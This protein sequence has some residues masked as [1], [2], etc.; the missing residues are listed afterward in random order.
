MRS[1]KTCVVSPLVTNSCFLFPAI[2]LTTRTVA[3][4]DE[5]SHHMIHGNE[6]FPRSDRVS[7]C[8]SWRKIFHY[9]FDQAP[10]LGINFV[11]ASQEATTTTYPVAQAAPEGAYDRGETATIHLGQ[12]LANLGLGGVVW[13]CV[14]NAMC[15][16]YV[17]PVIQRLLSLQTIRRGLVGLKSKRAKFW[18]A[19]DDTAN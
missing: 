19:G 9:P 15:E 13:D 2:C 7:A 18:T 3:S 17:R 10:T 11:R 4:V 16:G 14:S 6:F 5:S 8:S 1:C 12:D